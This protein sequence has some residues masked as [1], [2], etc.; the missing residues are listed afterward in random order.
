M[1]PHTASDFD[2]VKTVGRK[3]RKYR[4][5]AGMTQVDLAASCGMYRTYLSRVENGTAN[6]A[7]FVLQ[8]LA[9]ALKIDLRELVCDCEQMAATP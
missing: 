6:P 3:I 1:Y 5:L 2:T 4:L 9:V 8:S 7:L